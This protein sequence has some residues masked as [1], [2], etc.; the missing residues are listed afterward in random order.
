MLCDNIGLVWSKIYTSKK[1]QFE[2]VSIIHSTT[3][4]HALGH[5]RLISLLFM[6]SLS[7][8]FLIRRNFF[9]LLD[10]C[11][12]LR[13]KG[14]FAVLACLCINEVKCISIKLG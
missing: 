1:C 4:S 5:P 9:Y 6:A 8:T 10:K 11:D 2:D 12:G 3:A 7:N 14:P 13:E